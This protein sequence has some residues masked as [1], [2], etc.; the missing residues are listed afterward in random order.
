MNLN[1]TL[2]QFWEEVHASANRD[3][4]QEDLEAA[5]ARFEQRLV[6]QGFD[7]DQIEGLIE[8]VGEGYG[9]DWSVL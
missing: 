7:E 6:Y 9:M 4:C 3:A 5:L 1:W 8:K 2:V